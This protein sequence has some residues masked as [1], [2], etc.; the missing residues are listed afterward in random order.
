MFIR[1]TQLSI[2]CTFTSE[3]CELVHTGHGK[4]VSLPHAQRAL[5][6]TG[7][8]QAL[9]NTSEGFTFGNVLF[10]ALLHAYHQKGKHVLELLLFLYFIHCF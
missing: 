7:V 2:G 6:V 3:Q 1:W 9:R 8:Q 4:C 5:Q 10:E